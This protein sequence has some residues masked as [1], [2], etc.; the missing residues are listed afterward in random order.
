MSVTR[1]LML[2]HWMLIVIIRLGMHTAAGVPWVFALLWNENGNVNEILNTKHDQSRKSNYFAGKLRKAFHRDYNRKWHRNR[3]IPKP[4]IIRLY[5]NYNSQASIG[6]RATFPFAVPKTSR[7]RTKRKNLK[8]MLREKC[9]LLL[10]KLPFPYTTI[11]CA[12]SKL[13][14]Q[15]AE[16]IGASSK[17]PIHDYNCHRQIGTSSDVSNVM[18][19]EFCSLTHKYRGVS[20]RAHHHVHN[21][22][23]L[24]YNWNAGNENGARLL[25]EGIFRESFSLVLRPRF[26]IFCCCCSCV[27]MPYYQFWMFAFCRA[28]VSGCRMACRLHPHTHNGIEHMSYFIIQAKLC[29]FQCMAWIVTIDVFHFIIFG[30]FFHCFLH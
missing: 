22:D 8:I 28:C 27:C 6:F 21:V 10:F 3:N 26:G 7:A 23:W 24:L 19:R 30:S 29:T 11:R 2:P 25:P 4:A 13:T 9:F 15:H 16:M 14:T 18:R 20:I 17:N 12:F 5:P 1:R